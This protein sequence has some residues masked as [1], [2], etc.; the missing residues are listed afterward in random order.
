MNAPLM[1][2]Q[3]PWSNDLDVICSYLTSVRSG[4]DLSNGSGKGI[5]GAGIYD[6]C[7]LPWGVGSRSSSS[8]LDEAPRMI[9]QLQEGALRAGVDNRPAPDFLLMQDP[10]EFLF[11]RRFLN[12]Y[13][14]VVSG[15]RGSFELFQG[16]IDRCVQM[17]ESALKERR[18]ESP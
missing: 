12:D 7:G 15:T 16:R 4:S 18:T 14:V 10:E 1:G 11:C 3:M 6:Q 13:Y 2:G 5:Q 17:A 8:F 9:Y